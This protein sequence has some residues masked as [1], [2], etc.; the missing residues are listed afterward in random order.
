ME[1][2]PEKTQISA[3]E[4]K[5]IHTLSSPDALIQPGGY[6]ERSRVVI[7]R[8]ALT[9]VGYREDRVLQHARIVSHGQQMRIVQKWQRIHCS[10]RI[11]CRILRLRCSWK[12]G[13][14][15]ARS[16]KARHVSPRRLGPC[17]SA[18]VKICALPH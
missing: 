3:R 6:D 11:E 17:C 13:A 12:Q 9:R 4:I 15:K 1:C 14:L 16:L 18:R 7:G 2:K 8:V 10:F 5:W